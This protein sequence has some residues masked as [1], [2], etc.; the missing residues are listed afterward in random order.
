MSSL[1]L[2]MAKAVIEALIFASSEPLTTKIMA[3]I[4]G[5]DDHTVRQLIADL[6]EENRQTSRGIQIIEVANGYQFSTQSE[7]SPFVEKLQ[8]VPRNVGLS[9]A[10]IETLAI[11][12][13]KQPITKAEIESL[14]GVS[15]E[16]SLNTLLEK[17]LVEEGGRKEAPGR[18]IL[19]QTTKRF[20][21]YFGLNDLKELPKVPDWIDPGTVKYSND[22]LEA[23]N[24]G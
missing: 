4:I 9:Q 6:I 17:N 1:N 2:V 3:E 24:H 20:L 19:Y 12:A 23:G 8:K 5:I 13:Y 14:R 16:S 10:A 18:P 7:C 22:T 21:Q 11:I 15:V